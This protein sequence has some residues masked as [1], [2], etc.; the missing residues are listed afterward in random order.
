[1]TTTL[2]QPVTVRDLLLRPGGDEH[3]DT[4]VAA[5]HDYGALNGLISDVRGLTAPIGRAVEREVASVVDGFL[6][7]DLFDLAAGGWR[8]HTAL[9]EAARRT[10]DEPGSE[11]VVVL[12]NHRITSVHRPKIDVL[13]DG[14]RIGTLDVDL[15]VVFDLEGLIGIVRQARL[16][17]V[18]AGSCLITGSLAVQRITLTQ[19]TARID[20][21]PT[22]ELRHGVRLLPDPDPQPDPGSQR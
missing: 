4:L 14:S 2:Q 3:V 21:G 1:M 17:A 22:V 16:T 11:E 12:A 13:V 8:R 18:R 15:K 9:C 10:R 19:R 5:L 6:A 20:V 7:L